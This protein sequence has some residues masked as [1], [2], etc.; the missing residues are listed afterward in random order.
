M[1]GN[2]REQD[3]ATREWLYENRCSETTT[4]EEAIE[5]CRV[6]EEHILGLLA[7][8]HGRCGLCGEE[9]EDPHWAMDHDGPT[10]LG[11]LVEATE[12]DGAILLDVDNVTAVECP[13]CDEALNSGDVD[14]V[15]ECIRIRGRRVRTGHRMDES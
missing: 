1:S 15:S 9:V 11:E 14:E 12:W 2:T 5:W 6:Q 13:D 7:R 10:E 3:L 4:K 8:Q